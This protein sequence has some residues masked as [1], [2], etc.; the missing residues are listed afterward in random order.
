VAA[1]ATEMTGAAILLFD[2]TVL[3]GQVC[4]SDSVAKLTADL[5]FALGEGPGVDAHSQGLVVAEPDLHEPVQSRWAAFAPAAVAGG[6]CAVFAFPV[7]IGAARLGALCLYRDHHG[8]LTDDQYQDA[9]VMA[10]V[11]A[12]AI[13]S[14]Q[15]DAPSDAVSAEVL[16]EGD[17][18]FNVHQA[19]GMISVQLAIS[20][21][22]ALVVLRAHA[23]RVDRL[24]ADVAA[25]VVNRTKRFDEADGA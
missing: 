16:A 13:L 11:A 9:S 10:S 14:M 6:A 3:R 1:D 19:A 21:S 17:F 7:R 23:F 18:H 12:R 4:S 24:L 2:Q 8:P 5:Q 22:Q 20:V 15:A 25:D